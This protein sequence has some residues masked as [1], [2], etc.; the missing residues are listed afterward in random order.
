MEFVIL[1]GHLQAG[2]QLQGG[3]EEGTGAEGG[4]C[5]SG[6]GVGRDG[7]GVGNSGFSLGCAAG[8]EVSG[9]ALIEDRVY[10]DA[11]YV[12]RFKS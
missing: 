9:E 11:M 8:Q 10:K 2:C 7:G 3:S 1:D 4:G 12:D 5:G 6:L